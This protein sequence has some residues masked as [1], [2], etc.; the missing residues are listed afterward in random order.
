MTERELTDYIRVNYPRENE[1]CEWKEFKNLKNDFNGH[2]K[3]DA[4]SYISALSNM[5]GG[6]LVIGVKDKSLEIVGIDTCNY[7]KD[8]ARLRLNEFC[9][10]LPTRRV[11][12][13]R[14]C[15]KRHRKNRVDYP[16]PKTHEAQACICP[17]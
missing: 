17:Q 14:I 8:K 15:D 3:N 13:G 11:D 2:E 1:N 6:D 10:N 9:A 16:C 5:E 12:S 4:I 7:D